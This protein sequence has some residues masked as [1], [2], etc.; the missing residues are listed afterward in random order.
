MQGKML[1][2]ATFGSSGVLA[3]QS[4]ISLSKIHDVEAPQVGLG[5]KAVAVS[6]AA[7]ANAVKRCTACDMLN[8]WSVSGCL[9]TIFGYAVSLLG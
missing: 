5:K 3:R 9:W 4:M 6:K 8:L 7:C 1:D 2:N